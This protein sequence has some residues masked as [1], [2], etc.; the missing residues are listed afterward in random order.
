MRVAEK[1]FQDLVTISRREE[2]DCL[3]G[4][5]DCEYKHVR[6]STVATVASIELCNALVESHFDLFQ[7]NEMLMRTLKER[8]CPIVE[9]T[10]EKKFFCAAETTDFAQRRAVLQTLKSFVK[11]GRGGGFE[12]CIKTCLDRLVSSLESEMPAWLRASSLEILRFF[13]ADG[14]ICSFLHDAYYDPTKNGRLRHRNAVRE[15]LLNSSENSPIWV[16]HEFV[17]TNDE[18]LET[19]RCRLRRRAERIREEDAKVINCDEEEN[20]EK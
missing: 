18:F 4:A 8:F 10:L 2:D 15:Y 13:C 17:G 20:K 1:T 16:I 6:E 14:D 12:K 5:I 7:K 19:T 9:E 3:S 11:V